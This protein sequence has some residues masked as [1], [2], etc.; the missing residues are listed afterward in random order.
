VKSQKSSNPKRV[1]RFPTAQ[2]ATVQYVFPECVVCWTSSRLH[3]FS[4]LIAAHVALCVGR[5]LLCAIEF[6]FAAC[7]TALALRFFTAWRVVP[8]AKH[9]MSLEERVLRLERVVN[10]LVTEVRALCVAPTLPAPA[11]PVTATSQRRSSSRATAKALRKV[12]TGSNTGDLAASGNPRKRR[13]A[14]EVELVSVTKRRL[15]SEDHA[16]KTS[17]TRGGNV[18]VDVFCEVTAPRPAALTC[19]I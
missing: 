7:A 8:V 19:G 9:T 16:A 4:V 11:A 13:S 3:I 6:W 15:S 17:T 10:T 14:D 2:R 12:T 18:R 1:A 5:V